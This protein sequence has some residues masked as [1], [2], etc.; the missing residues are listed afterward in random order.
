M[1][2]VRSTS[3]WVVVAKPELATEGIPFVIRGCSRRELDDGRVGWWYIGGLDVFCT[4]G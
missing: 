2:S 3:G 1:R 4:G